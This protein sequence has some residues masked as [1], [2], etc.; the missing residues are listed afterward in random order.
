MHAPYHKEVP[1]QA[2]ECVEVLEEREHENHLH[3]V[4]EPDQH[5]DDDGY[6]TTTMTI[7]T[8]TTTTMV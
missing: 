7:M 6:E 5:H 4:V 1:R 3:L 8:T 2:F